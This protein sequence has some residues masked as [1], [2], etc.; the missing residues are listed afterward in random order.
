MAKFSKLT[1]GTMTVNG[2]GAGSDVVI[3]EISNTI[4]D[5]NTAL[6]TSDAVYA[7]LQRIGY[8]PYGSPVE[9]MISGTLENQQYCDNPPDLRGLTF[10][11]KYENSY[12]K[13]VPVTDSHITA[14]NWGSTEGHLTTTVY[15]T[16]NGVS[17]SNTI[18]AYCIPEIVVFRADDYNP[19]GI[20]KTDL[21]SAIYA[22]FD[23]ENADDQGGYDILGH[24]FSYMRKSNSSDTPPTRAIEN[25]HINILGHYRV[26][27]STVDLPSS[28][29]SVKTFN[30]NLSRLYGVITARVRRCLAAGTRIAWESLGDT[31]YGGTYGTVRY[32]CS[33]GQWSGPSGYFTNINDREM[34]S[35]VSLSVWNSNGDWRVADDY[36]FTA[37]GLLLRIEF[38]SAAG[39]SPQ[40]YED[41]P[42]TTGTFCSGGIYLTFTYP[43]GTITGPGI[44][45]INFTVD[46]SPTS[47][48]DI[49]NKYGDVIENPSVDMTF[50]YKESNILISP[51][52]PAS[53]WVAKDYSGNFI[54]L[55]PLYHF[56]SSHG[57]AAVNTIRSGS[58]LY[59]INQDGTSTQISSNIQEISWAD[60]VATIK[61]KDSSLVD[62]EITIG[63]DGW[64]RNYTLTVN[65]NPTR[66][67]GS[68]KY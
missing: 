34:S 35:A 13:Y 32:R 54:D 8:V 64:Y 45:G 60:N 7:E 48:A 68:T 53:Q 9:L 16:E 4:S 17:V 26:Y 36:T 14:D 31:K 5:S 6:I 49:L 3:D 15:Y 47:L 30:V 2:A 63:D 46:N 55:H 51:G 24:H 20:R 10:Y 19:S 61:Y 29:T 65:A 43:Y 41:N 37:Q 58:S 67:D 33:A 50:R 59:Y 66:S 23:N 57:T 38:G 56:K 18:N 28:T 25:A 39:V 11:V 12:H 42:I 1:K 21:N 40:G 22:C 62:Q 44:W 52:T 27:V